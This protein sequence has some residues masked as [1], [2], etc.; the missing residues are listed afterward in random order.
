MAIKECKDR[1]LLKLGGNNLFF[2]Q[3]YQN[4]MEAQG[5]TYKILIS[6]TY[7]IPITITRKIFFKYCSLLSEPITYSN[8]EESLR[9]FLDDLCMYLKGKGVQIITSTPAYTSFKDYPSNSKRIPFGNYV[10]D[11]SLSEEDLFLK[12]HSKHRN[13]IR[14][15][16]KDGVEISYGITNDLLNDFCKLDELT[17]KRSN[18]NS[19]GINYY[20]LIIDTIPT[21]SLIFVAYYNNTPQSAALIYYDK[22]MGYYMYGANANSPHPGS[23]NYL[24]WEIMLYL[25]KNGV[26]KYSFVGCRI[27]E[28]ETSKYHD[29][30]RF[31][32][33]FGG[34]LIKSYLFKS[35]LR[36]FMNKLMIV[37]MKLLR[38]SVGIDA[39]DEEIHKWPELNK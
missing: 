15:A 1:S 21:N 20:K 10:V 26:K 39:I 30:Q 9:V 31:K 13:S 38:K 16:K 36:P 8:G 23:G 28:D 34:E 2:S 35:Y 33:R 11:L 14:K 4:L 22:N 29:I 6:N 7:A 5:R 24:Q 27:N 37:A 25:K 18:A 12:V 17:W 3:Q 32:E 19:Y